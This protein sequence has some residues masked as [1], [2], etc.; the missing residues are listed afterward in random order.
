[1]GR[2]L[3]AL[4]CEPHLLVRR[5]SLFVAQSRTTV[6]EGL[7]AGTDPPVRTS[8]V[9]AGR[10][11][12]APPPANGGQETLRDARPAPARLGRPPRAAGELRPL[13]GREREQALELCAQVVDVAR[14]EAREVAERGRIFRLEALGHLGEPRVPGD[15]RRRARGGRL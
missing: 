13:L 8:H 10:R 6:V 15:E 7:E 1:V 5:E 4:P 11:G 14:L 3:E 12:L 9:R 2:R